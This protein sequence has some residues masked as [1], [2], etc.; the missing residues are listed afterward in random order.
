MS[1][2]GLRASSWPVSLTLSALATWRLTHL[3][4]EEDGPADVVLRL[5]RVAGSSL[6]GQAMDCFYC[7]SVWVA[8]PI[9]MGLTSERVA[10]VP[11]ARAG[12]SRPAAWVRRSVAWLALSGAACLRAGDPPAESGGTSMSC[13]GQRRRALAQPRPTATPPSPATTASP[14]SAVQ[15][16]LGRALARHR[17]GT[18][19]AASS[20]QTP[21]TTITDTTMKGEHT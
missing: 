17:Q 14:A 10:M 3:L 20:R 4:T 21:I 12:R 16:A 13:C 7:T 11:P 5:R 18:A 6:L 8:L 9:A 2:I 15:F 19:A 1:G